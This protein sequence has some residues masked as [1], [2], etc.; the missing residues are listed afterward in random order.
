M[1]YGQNE[2]A[3]PISTE[4]KD[5][6]AWFCMILELIL[7]KDYSKATSGRVDDQPLDSDMHI[8]PR[9]LIYTAGFKI[10]P[11]PVV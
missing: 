11:D 8:T 2:K 4:L 1:T 9:I 7:V 10:L 6:C 5:P 3:L